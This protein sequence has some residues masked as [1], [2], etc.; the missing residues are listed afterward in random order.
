MTFTKSKLLAAASAVVLVVIAIRLGDRRINHWPVANISATDGPIICF[1]DS[2]VAGV[3]KEARDGSYPAQ[4]ALILE[5]DVAALGVPGETAQDGLERLARESQIRNCPVIVT[6][7][8]NDLLQRQPWEQTEEALRG[9]FAELQ[10]RGCLV[11]YTGV[12]G[13]AGGQAKHR[14]LCKHAGVIL[15]PDLLDEITGNSDLKSDLIHPNDAGYRVIA[16]KV[17][18]YLRPFLEQR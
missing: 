9:I 10:R 6:L 15:I 14:R 12:Q 17:A 16:E 13:I 2:L 8:G 4:L 7:G 1:G 11:A 18:A 3:G 5:R